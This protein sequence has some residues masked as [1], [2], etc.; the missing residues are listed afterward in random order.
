[1]HTWFFPDLLSSIPVQIIFMLDDSAADLIA[2]K[3]VR[4]THHHMDRCM[5]RCMDRYMD[6]YATET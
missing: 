5:D 3:M 1:M 6:R 4:P 2:L